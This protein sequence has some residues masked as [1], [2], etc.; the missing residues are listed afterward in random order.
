MAP[1]F[2]YLNTSIS[3]GTVSWEMKLKDLPGNDRVS[4]GV[5][6]VSNARLKE[7]RVASD[8]WLYCALD[9]K[10]MFTCM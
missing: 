4:F 3:S 8:M 7:G 2:A 10:I 1:A 5:T 9:G 6:P